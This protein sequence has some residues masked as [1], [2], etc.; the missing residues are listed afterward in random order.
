[1]TLRDEVLNPLRGLPRDVLAGSAVLLRLLLR[2]LLAGLRAASTPPEKPKPAPKKRAGRRPAVDDE[3]QEQEQHEDGDE[4][5]ERPRPLR[6]KTAAR[7]GADQLERAGMAVL[8]LILAIGSIGTVA[9][10]LAPWAPAILGG[11]TVAWVIAAGIA[12]PPRPAP[13][14]PEPDEEQASEEASADRPEHLLQWLL[15]VM[16]DRPG[17]HLAELYPLMREI[18][19][20]GGR[21]DADFRAALRAL[22]IPVQRTLRV[23]KVA[24]R[25]GIARADVDALLSPVESGAGE[26]TVE[27][28]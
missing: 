25:S 9:T 4:D 26:K 13:Q 10:L 6:G 3:D 2:A 21:S 11:L 15:E 7:S 17:I 8:V 14:P 20:Q 27:L 22:D 16:G 19:G 24:G 28:A 1:M 18:P 12:A 5:A 23:G